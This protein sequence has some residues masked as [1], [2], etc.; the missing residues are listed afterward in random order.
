MLLLEIISS[1]VSTAN[2]INSRVENIAKNKARLNALVSK[3]TSLSKLCERLSDVDNL[4]THKEILLNINKCTLDI[5]HF[6]DKLTDDSYH[7]M[8]MNFKNAGKH[9]KQIDDFNDSLKA[10]IDILNVALHIGSWE[11]AD[12]HTRVSQEVEADKLAI[13]KN[14][15]E[16]LRDLQ[17]MLS[18][19][20]LDKIVRMQLASFEC[21]F[22]QQRMNESSVLNDNERVNLS[23]L[24]FKRYLGRSELGEVYEGLWHGHQP[25]A[26]RWVENIV[27]QEENRRF[28]REIGILRQ[29]NNPYITPFYGAC[30]EPGR[31][32]FLTGISEKGTLEDVF[33]TLTVK[34]RLIVLRDLARGLSYLHERDVVHANIHP[35]AVGITKHYQAQWTEF[36]FSKTSLQGIQTLGD[37]R[38]NSRVNNDYEAPEVVAGGQ[39]T[40]A[41]D[42]YSFGRLFATL[43]T[44][45][46]PYFTSESQFHR[47]WDDLYCD[48]VLLC[49]SE[50]PEDRPTALEVARTLDSYIE[51]NYDRLR[52]SVSPTPGVANFEQGMALEQTAK[53]AGQPV[54]L[55]SIELYEKASMKGCAEASRRL[56]VFRAEGRKRYPEW[57]IDKPK[58][59]LFFKLGA[60]QGDAVSAY[61]MAKMYDEG[62]ITGEPDQNEALRCYQLCLALSESS[63]NQDI[64]AIRRKAE[65]KI[66]ILQGKSLS[67]AYTSC[68]R[69]FG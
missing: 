54:P 37:S 46:N 9:A 35:K 55:Q 61:N 52:R 53:R 65:H 48:C 2:Q 14:Q 16:M 31:Y 44:K 39:V 13:L 57:D 29:L 20:R 4:Q 64:L 27:L 51:S 30:T 66:S 8:V 34:N 28:I 10:H 6:L 24:I 63:N 33:P 25:V 62:Q 67:S 50:R 56:G 18:T 43:M 15:E 60:D 47:I 42:I 58:A 7:R 49:L 36:G 22:N 21:R 68:C 45:E 38:A 40:Q 1:I 26:I 69:R 23:D 19:T 41:S 59:L 12:Q 17:P 5:V 3:V 11:R 32:C